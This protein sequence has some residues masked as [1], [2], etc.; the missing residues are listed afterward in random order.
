M[1]QGFYSFPSI[2]DV[3]TRNK[4][5]SYLEHEMSVRERRIKRV[6]AILPGSRKFADDLRSITTTPATP[7]PVKRLLRILIKDPWEDYE[8][9]QDLDQVILARPKA[10]YFKLVNIRQFYCVDPLQESRVL[11]STQHP[12]VASIHNIYCFHNETFLITEHL[13]I[14]IS[15]LELQ[16]YELEEWEI[17]T[18]IAEV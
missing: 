17:A 6:K 18:I 1:F 10:S 2:P 8:Y 3:N 4:A 11:S 5:A 12:N 14:A 13:H 16:K 7:S 9:V 15:Q